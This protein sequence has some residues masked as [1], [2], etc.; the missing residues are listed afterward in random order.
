MLKH[1]CHPGG[2]GLG[3]RLNRSLQPPKME[4]VQYGSSVS[5]DR[6]SAKLEKFTASLAEPRLNIG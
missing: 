2:P 4:P 5:I 6:H 1:C 3:M